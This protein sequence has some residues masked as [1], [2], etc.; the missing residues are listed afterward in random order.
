MAQ[1]PWF[2]DLLQITTT[3]WIHVFYF[4]EAVQFVRGTTVLCVL[5]ISS[6]V[7][8]SQT[9]AGISAGP[10]WMAAQTFAAA[11]PADGFAGI[12]IQ[13]GE[14]TCDQALAFGG[15]TVTVPAGAIL[16]LNLVPAVPTAGP[17]EFPAKVKEAYED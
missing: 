9:K 2:N 3:K 14:L 7:T 15:T 13:S 10:A 4:V 8:G 16:N 1:S 6:S 17:A 5:P 11:A 12:T